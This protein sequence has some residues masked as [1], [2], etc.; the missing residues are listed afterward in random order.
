M[1]VWPLIEWGGRRM[2]A[3]FWGRKSTGRGRV[4]D[5][6]RYIMACACNVRRRVLNLSFHV[7]PSS[8]FGVHVDDPVIR[9][10]F[11]TPCPVYPPL[12]L[13]SSILPKS[14]AS[15]G[16][17]YRA[18]DYFQSKRMNACKKRKEKNNGGYEKTDT[19]IE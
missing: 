9:R 15:R 11:F 10:Y 8:T 18:G 2:E 17:T 13:P 3:G 16:L 1:K 14:P 7:Q 6:D 12:L 5:G 19:R 4:A